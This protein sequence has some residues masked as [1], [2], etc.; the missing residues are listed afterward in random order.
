MT[1]N[2]AVQQSPSGPYAHLSEPAANDRLLE[3]FYTLAQTRRT[4][5]GREN[6]Q[7]LTTFTGPVALMKPD[8]REAGH[9]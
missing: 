2:G 5:R 7:E 6:H 1:L 4:A 9:G 3:A 8:M